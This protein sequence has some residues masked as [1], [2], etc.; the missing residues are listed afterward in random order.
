LGAGFGVGFLLG[1]EVLIESGEMPVADCR[2]LA[3]VGHSFWSLTMAAF[4]W[5]GRGP[6]TCQAFNTS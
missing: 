2:A 5:S 3:S 1:F 6:M 4:C